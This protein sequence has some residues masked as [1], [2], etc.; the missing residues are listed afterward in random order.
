MGVIQELA[1]GAI[2]FKN[3]SGFISLPRNPTIFPATVNCTLY[4]FDKSHE[5]YSD[6][7]LCAFTNGMVKGISR[8]RQ[9]KSDGRICAIFREF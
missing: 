1:C 4:D 8:L 3:S 5:R 9:R 2:L 7:R 6:Q